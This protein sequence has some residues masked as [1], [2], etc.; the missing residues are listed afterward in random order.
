MTLQSGGTA[1][2]LIAQKAGNH[3]MLPGGESMEKGTRIRVARSTNN[4]IELLRF[5]RD[6]LGLEVLSSFV[7]HQGFDGVMLG[8]PGE[9]WHLEFTT[10]HG[11]MAGR[12]P[13]LE[14]LL[15]FYI[16]QVLQWEAAIARMKS[17]GFE[18]V[19]SANPYWDLQGKTF[20]DI[21]GYRVVLQN[22][23]WNR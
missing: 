13:T 22:A 5:Y 7:D 2:D 19:E 20:E 9:P 10:Q 16:P 8:L 11:H 18:P 12:A 23:T 21:D 14:N 3:A 15:V 1:S 6:G 4:T 17:C